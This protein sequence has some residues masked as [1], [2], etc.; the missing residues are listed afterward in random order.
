MEKENSNGL[1]LVVDDNPINT[2]QIKDMLGISGFQSI[3]AE[4]ASEGL[5][6]VKTIKPDLILLDIVMPE[7]NGYTFCETL[8]SDPAFTDIPIIFITAKIEVDTFEL[9]FKAGANDFMKKPTLKDLQSILQL[10]NLI[11]HDM[12]DQGF[13]HWNDNYPNKEV[14]LKD[15]KKRCLY[16]RTEDSK[17][18]GMISFDKSHHELFNKADWSDSSG[19][20][21]FVHRLG[22]LPERQ[23]EGIASILMDF[24]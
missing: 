17:I 23:G 10:N 14:Y 7:T 3:T 20:Y 22:I 6:I 21:Y 5:E 8:K 19:D 1:V 15:I 24:A 16:L 2:Q 11:K 9:A 12:L 13:H 18:V 4:S